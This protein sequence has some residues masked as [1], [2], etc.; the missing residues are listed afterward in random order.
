MTVLILIRHATNDFV[1][2]GRLAGWTPGVHLNAEGQREADSLAKRLVH[3]PIEAIYAS[4][5]ERAM[6]TADAIA[7]CHHLPVEVREGLGEG[8]I[9][10]WTG[11]SI[12]ELQDTEVWKAMQKSPVGVKPPGGESIDEVQARM[13]AAIDDIRRQHKEGIVA[14]VSHADPLKAAISH[15]MGWDLNDFQR[16]AISPASASVLLVDDE[17]SVLLLLNHA[18]E[19][20][21]IERPK[22][23]KESA[24]EKSAGEAPEPP[25]GVRKDETKMTEA[26]L[27]YDLN[28]VSRVMTGA[29]GEPG[30]RVFYLQARQG[31]TLIT[32]QA[33]KEQIQSLTVGINDLLEKLGKRPA[34]QESTSA[35]D[36]ALEQ[37]VEP[38]FQIGQLGLGFDREH[39][40]LVI[41]AYEIAAQEERATVDYVRFWGTR[42]QMRALAQHA[43][44]VVAGGR[45]ICVLC[46]KPIDPE[47]HFCPRRNGHG[48]KAPLV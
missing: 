27:L 39:D 46:G 19:I 18:G 42:D 23:K 41:V 40:L 38:L 9:G 11:K 8:R 2:D 10:E 26:N 37:P 1:R 15:Y 13:V 31:A 4:P 47:G 35:Y 5:L 44:E 48:A 43:A 6:D 3:L 32:L 14:V 21:K 22:E 12:K 36:V 7:A 29:V 25:S 28:P 24:D 17:T 33:E 16:I 34:T 20:P 45:P 30:H